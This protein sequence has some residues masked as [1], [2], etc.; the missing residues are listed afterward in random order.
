MKDQPRKTVIE[1]TAQ[2]NSLRAVSSF[3]NPKAT[4]CSRLVLGATAMLS[5]AKSNSRSWQSVT[6]LKT[7]IRVSNLFSS[8][9]FGAT[10]KVARHLIFAVGWHVRIHREVHADEI[11]RRVDVDA[12]SDIAMLPERAVLE[13]SVE[14][15]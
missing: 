3:A 7:E 11:A 15:H 8:Q 1:P 10:T 2:F 14:L 4:Q 12:L 5:D 6:T 9:I 13:D